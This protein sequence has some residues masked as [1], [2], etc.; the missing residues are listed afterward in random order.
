M[1]WV[2][3]QPAVACSWKHLT[4]QI[5]CQPRRRGAHRNDRGA[6]R[7]LLVGGS[8]AAARGLC[9]R[10]TRGAAR[11]A[12]RARPLIPSAAFS[13]AFAGCPPFIAPSSSAG[14][15]ALRSIGSCAS[16]QAAGAAGES[17]DGLRE[18]EEETGTEARGREPLTRASGGIVLQGL[19]SERCLRQLRLAQD[20]AELQLTHT[21]A[22]SL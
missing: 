1:S 4:I 9:H 17:S 3:E 13:S 8:P 10:R 14:P 18:A 15:S 21:C 20:R 19:V 22:G 7:R 5:S 12:P 6:A 2:S 16:M 11:L